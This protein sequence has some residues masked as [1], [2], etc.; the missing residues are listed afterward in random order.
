MKAQSFNKIHSGIRRIK[1]PDA[2]LWVIFLLVTVIIYANILKIP[3]YGDDYYFLFQDPS[4]SIIE[5]F[6]LERTD[7]QFF[8]PLQVWCLSVLQYF[9]GENTL[10]IHL[11]HIA[12]H[13]WLM[14]AVLKITRIIRYSNTQKA[15]VL[16]MLGLSQV[17]VMAIASNDTLSMI[18]SVAF[19]VYAIFL[20]LKY[21]LG[22][23]R[24]QLLLS[25]LC[26]M[27]ALL[28]KESAVAFF[29]ILLALM[30][31]HYRAE[32]GAKRKYLSVII[33][34][35]S[36]LSIYMLS[37]SLAGASLPIIGDG[38][39]AFAFGMNVLVN[40]LQLF[41]ATFIPVATP[42]VFTWYQEGAILQLALSTIMILV[43]ISMLMWS[44]IDH[45][46]QQKIML[47]WLLCF[48]LSFIPVVF[49]GH[50]SELYA[51][52]LLPF[53]ALFSG[54]LLGKAMVALGQKNNILW[55]AFLVIYGFLHF[56]AIQ[57]KI[58][59][60]RENGALAQDIREALL[61]KLAALPKHQK[62]YLVYQNQNTSYSVFN[63]SGFEV[64]KHGEAGIKRLVK[65][66][67]LYLEVVDEKG[68]MNR[69]ADDAKYWKWENGNILLID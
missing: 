50:V 55:M 34:L 21:L 39:Y 37:R 11:L 8:R 3:F 46:P 67:D 51:Y 16:T 52:A 45:K 36:V 31:W 4:L 54:A 35:A 48:F 1:L 61:P 33:V 29:P 49:M 18:G 24:I 28:F 41:V 42:Q 10:S 32:K 40:G 15:L 44:F 14:L 20:M 5:A 23:R 38:T 26:L 69:S 60:M 2:A 57:S 22:Y 53:A 64:L 63:M 19:G 47:V 65:R 25:V 17:P 30:V 6:R 59:S 27:V 56:T 66:P 43:F 9:F 12:L 58:Q 7:Y 13:A 68:L 62:V